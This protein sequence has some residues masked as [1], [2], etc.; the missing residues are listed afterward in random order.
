MRKSDRE[1]GW[2]EQGGMSAARP[3]AVGRG[4]VLKGCYMGPEGGHSQSSGNRQHWGP[5]EGVGQ[6]IS[7]ADRKGGGIEYIRGTEYRTKAALVQRAG[8]EWRTELQ[9]EIKGQVNKVGLGKRSSQVK[10]TARGRTFPHCFVHLNKQCLPQITY[11]ISEYYCI[12]VI[13]LP[14]CRNFLLTR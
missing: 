13:H 2:K 3:A 9:S 12:F 7:K 5:T 14:K 1:K 4:C 8:T 11:S 6:R 10:S